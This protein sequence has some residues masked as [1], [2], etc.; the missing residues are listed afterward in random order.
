MNDK[1]Y[2]YAQVDESNYDLFKIY[3]KGITVVVKENK[4][5]N[6]HQKYER[7]FSSFKV[8]LKPKSV[9]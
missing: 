1:H 3:W 6:T 5:N 4:L 7:T 9:E 2:S 8:H